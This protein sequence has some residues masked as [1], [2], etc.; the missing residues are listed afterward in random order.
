MPSLPNHRSIRLRPQIILPEVVALVVILSTIA[1]SKPSASVWLL[2]IVVF[3]LHT[4]L[5]Y[6]CG[7]MSERVRAQPS[8]NFI[9]DLRQRLRERSQPED[10]S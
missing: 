10:N 2:G 8:P 7:R 3:L 4:I 5:F 9:R 6:R 1:I